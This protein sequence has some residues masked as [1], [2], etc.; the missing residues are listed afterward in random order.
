MLLLLH[1][2]LADEFLVGKALADDLRDY[3]AETVAVIQLFP[4][5]VPK[6]LL[7]QVTKQVERLNTHVGAVEPALQQAP[8]GFE[9]IEYEQR[10]PRRLRR[11]Q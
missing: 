3:E 5:V 7:I 10:H 8:K 1:S 4:V 6:R 2:G 9:S 11:G